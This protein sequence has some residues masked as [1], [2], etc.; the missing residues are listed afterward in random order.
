MFKWFRKGI[1]EVPTR[2]YYCNEICD[3]NESDIICGY[4]RLYHQKCQKDVLCSPENYDIEQVSYA[5]GVAQAAKEFN[6]R[7][8]KLCIKAKKFCVED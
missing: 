7:K 5:V 6:E 8:K 1:T 2:C 3:I 4:R